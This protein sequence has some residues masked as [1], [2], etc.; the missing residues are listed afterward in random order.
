MMSL[1]V[2][3]PSPPHQRNRPDVGA[4][5]CYLV[6]GGVAPMATSAFLISD[7]DVL[8]HDITIFD[9]RDAIGASLDASG[10][11]NDGYVL[12]GGR[13]IESKSSAHSI[14]SPPFPLWTRPKRSRRRFSAGTRR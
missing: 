9:E 2:A 1:D 4:S 7:G 8:G 5:Q 13:M 12:C 3:R 14:S 11:A 6:G 10:S